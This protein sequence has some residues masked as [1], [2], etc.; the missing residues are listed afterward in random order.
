MGIY[1]IWLE[2]T[3]FHDNVRSSRAHSDE[4]K[5]LWLYSALLDLGRFYNFLILYTLWDSLDGGSACRKVTTY[6]Q[7]NTNTD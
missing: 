7:D 3:N 6:A 4:V 5:Y 1:F 2:K